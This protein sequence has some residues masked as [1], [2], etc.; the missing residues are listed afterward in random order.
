MTHLRLLF[1][2]RHLLRVAVSPPTSQVSCPKPALSDLSSAHAVTNGERSSTENFVI[3][4]LLLLV[5]GCVGYA[6]LD[7]PATSNVHSFRCSLSLH[8]GVALVR[9]QRYLSIAMILSNP[10][11]AIFVSVVTSFLFILYFKLVADRWRCVRNAHVVYLPTHERPV[12]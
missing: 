4:M 9:Q 11:P 8:W 12:N 10:H 1:V 2:D 3:R 7:K 5:W 6:T